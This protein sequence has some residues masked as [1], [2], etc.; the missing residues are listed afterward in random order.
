MLVGMHFRRLGKLDLAIAQLRKAAYI[1]PQS[2]LVQFHL[3]EA[4]HASGMPAE[5]ARAYRNALAAL[6][7]ASDRDIRAYAGG[8]GRPALKTF[9]E[10]RLSG[11]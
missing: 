3:G 7:A 11:Q 5:A 4:C 10:Q 1:A 9:C 8:F 6:P 2:C